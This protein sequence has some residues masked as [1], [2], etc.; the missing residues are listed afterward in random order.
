MF[1]SLLRNTH[2]RWLSWRR[3]TIRNSRKP[4]GP[5][6]R[7][8]VLQLEDRVLPSTASLLKDIGVALAAPNPQYL[9]AVGST[10]YFS[11]DDGTGAQLG[12]Y[13]GT[14]F[15]EVRVGTYA[16]PTPLYLTA[17]GSTLYFNA[18][19]GTGGTGYQLW[20]Y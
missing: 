5:K 6:V 4:S 14:T 17:V 12:K 11:A 15:T 3:S 7:L 9:T 20:Q 13:D 1:P 19:D 18:S 10:L 2:R 16:S 8:Q